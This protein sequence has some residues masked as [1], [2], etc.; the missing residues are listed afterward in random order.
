MKFGAMPVA[1]A[2]GAILAHGVK[3]G[4]GVFKK[5]R[6][7]SAADI[8]ELQSAGITNVIVARLDDDDVGEDIA[9][10]QLA[11]VSAGQG[12]TAQQAFTGRANLHSSVH[13]L[14]VVDRTRVNAINHIHESLTL[15]TLTPHSVVAPK[16]MLATVKIIPFAVKDEVL[17]GALS[18]VGDRPLLH[19]RLFQK[20][21]IGLIITTV[22][23][24]KP[25]IIAKSEASI[26]DRL[27]ALGLDLK[28]VVV[29][30]HREADVE[31]SIRSFSEQGSD[32]ILVFGGSA[33]VDR[34]DVIPAALVA[35]GGDVVHLGMP[36][37]PGNLLMLGQLDEAPVIGVPSCARSPKRNGF[38][39][40]LERVLAG[41]T[42]T[43]DDIMDMGVGGL[44]AEI[45]SRP[46]PREQQV[47]NTPHITAVVLAAG[48]GKRMGG[49]KMLADFG[50]KP[51]I[52]AT[53]ENILASG[54][55]DVIV[56][57]GHEAQA[58]ELAVEGTSSV[59]LRR[60]P[61]PT[62]LEK[63][64]VTMFPSPSQDG[65]GG[66]KRRMRSLLNEEL[67]F[68]HN[69]NYETGMASSLCV[70]VEAAKNADAVIICLGDMP[71]VS[72]EVIDRMI[73]AFNPTEHRSIVVPTHKGQ[74]GN[75]VLW[76]AEHFDRLT[77]MQGDK[78]AR[79]LIAGLK[80]EAT[81]IEADAGV[82]M[83]ADTPEDLAA[84]KSVANSE[85]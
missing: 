24:T 39:W 56:V 3:H 43:G 42:V 40:V 61:S 58:V 73:A 51:M 76:G 71:R 4:D 13:G 47:P 26:R 11:V 28:T 72:A 30:P 15:A 59:R 63:G 37:D 67:Q 74:F 35:A 54:V 20:K 84:L 85:S 60:P 5:G 75:P 34:G 79:H 82:L 1:E 27:Q 7:L 49:A 46:S 83:D 6:V 8:V 64:H 10:R 33:I 55:D 2:L 52:V 48:M 62:L 17:K 66:A 41:L 12:V 80:S 77:S 19:V 23:Q 81:E 44:L 53:I 29:V 69:P 65:E 45:P 68:I 9:A 32:C 78:G 21:H 22:A 18:I 16:Q 31:Q 36:V 70:G 14:V 25:S 57:T 50:G 38:D